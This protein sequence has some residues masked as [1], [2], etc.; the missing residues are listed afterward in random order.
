[1]KKIQPINIMNKFSLFNEQWTPKILVALNDQH[2][3]ICR[4]KDNFVCH[5]HNHEDDLLMLFKVT[6]LIY[7]RD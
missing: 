2:V 3:K 1:M 5:R 6:L 4:L 7:F